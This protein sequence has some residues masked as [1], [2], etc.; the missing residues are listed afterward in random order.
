MTPEK[1]QKALLVL[2]V[3]LM[4]CCVVSLPVTIHRALDSISK[5]KI[6]RNHVNINSNENCNKC[7]LGESFLALFDH[8]MVKKNKQLREDT[9]IKA[10]IKVY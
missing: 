4:I 7:H 1:K 10:K 8:P 2:V 6:I 3:V 9:M 5:N